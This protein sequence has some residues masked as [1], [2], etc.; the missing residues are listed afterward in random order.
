MRRS[1]IGMV[2]RKWCRSFLLL[3]S[4]LLACAP[5]QDRDFDPD[6]TYEV[7]ALQ[8][9]FKKLARTLEKH[10]PTLCLFQD[11]SGFTSCLDSTYADIDSAMTVKE[12]YL[13]LS[14]VVAR[15]RCGHTC[16]L[17]PEAHWTMLSIRYPTF[18]LRLFYTDKKA[19]VLND[20]GTAAI[21]TGSEILSINGMRASEIIDNYLLTFASDGPNET[22]RYHQMNL[23]PFGLFPGYP[24]F[25]DSYVVV[26]RSPD[27]SLTKVTTLR[28]RHFGRSSYL[29]W[30]SF[31][32]MAGGP[33]LGF[34]TID[35]LSTAVLTIRTFISEPGDYAAFFRN[36]FETIRD[37]S[38][39]NLILDLRGNDGGGP[40]G[41]AELLSYLMSSEY[42]Y[43]KSR[44]YGY[45]SLKRAVPLRQPGFRGHLYILIDGG[46]FSTT[47]HL[48]S[49][50][51]YHN[52]GTLI[53]E[54]SGGSYWCNGCNE[55]YT[56][57]NTS[58]RLQYTRC[59]YETAVTGLP[60]GRGVMPDIEVRPTLKDLLEGKDTVMRFT[61]DL[62]RVSAK[63][64]R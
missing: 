26:C 35:S 14:R 2:N 27:D 56:L 11:R 40:E 64:R 24:D 10:H 16:I 51:R 34:E 8:E 17:F 23:K 59:T 13:I 49:L 62:I 4:L 47:G 1:L 37:H 48:L 18:P 32:D 53:G 46:C 6:R 60:R 3:A 29:R 45:R 55:I 5:Q 63:P 44:V 31:E 50:V 42:V 43:F 25:P 19:Y 15:I 9:D 41:S 22:F 30:E 54:E 36:A 57:P 20:Y 39:A 61:L 38:L 33:P 7:T 52:L 12:F 58:L 28:A 21:S